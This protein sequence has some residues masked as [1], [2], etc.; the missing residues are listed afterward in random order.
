MGYDDTTDLPAAQN[1]IDLVVQV[2]Q[3]NTP[4][5]V[6]EHGQAPLRGEL[7]PQPLAVGERAVD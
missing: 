3:P 5:H 7:L 2:F 4:H 1:Q 6:V